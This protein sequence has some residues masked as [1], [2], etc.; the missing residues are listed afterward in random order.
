ML[1]PPGRQ[2]VTILKRGVY[3]DLTRAN[4]SAIFTAQ[5][6]EQQNKAEEFSRNS[7]LLKDC[8]EKTRQLTVKTSDRDEESRLVDQYLNAGNALVETTLHNPDSAAS[9]LGPY[10]QL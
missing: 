2:F 8:I 1:L 5:G 3:N 10:L 6:D 7:K 9:H 4:V